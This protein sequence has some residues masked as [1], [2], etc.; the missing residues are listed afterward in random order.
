M[1]ISTTVSPI[2]VFTLVAIISLFIGI[3]FLMYNVL[4]QGARDARRKTDLHNIALA[5]EASYDSKNSAYS[6]IN[7][8]FFAYHNLPGDPS[9]GSKNCSRRICKY[10]FKEQF[11]FCSLDDKDLTEHLPE[12]KKTFKICVNLE[13]GGYFCVQNQR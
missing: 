10:C 7:L 8:D 13:N 2:R 12:S 5:L 1:E 9:V 4:A 6:S 3:I 11:G